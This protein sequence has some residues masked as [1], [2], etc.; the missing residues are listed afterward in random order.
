MTT[1][2]KLYIDTEEELLDLAK[3]WQNRLLLRDWFKR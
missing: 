1:E 2:P 3:E